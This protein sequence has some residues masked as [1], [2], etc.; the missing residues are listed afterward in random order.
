VFPDVKGPIKSLLQND[1]FAK[2][3]EKYIKEGESIKESLKLPYLDSFLT[4]YV[5][6]SFRRWFNR[7]SLFLGVK[8]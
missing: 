7:V 1:F 4:R 5:Y 3:R 6:H 8:N 2:N